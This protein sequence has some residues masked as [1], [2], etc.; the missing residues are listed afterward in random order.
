[1]LFYFT[2]F[3]LLAVPQFIL[4]QNIVI[5]NSNSPNE[6][7][8]AMDY[9]NPSKM[10]AG[11]NLNNYYISQDTGRTWTI[12]SL[13]SSTLGV[14]GDP[15]M[16]I[17]TAGVYYFLHLSNPP[18]GN[19]IDRIV[20][21]RSTDEGLTWNDGTYMGLNGTKAQDKE[22]VDIDRNKNILYV[23]WTQFDNY[24]S[25]NPLDSSSILFSKSTDQGL[26]WSPALRINE[27]SGDC[28]DS[29]N[30][31]EGAVPAVGPNGEIYVAWAGPEGIVF[32]RSTDEGS[33]WL[34]QDIPV[35]PMPTGWDYSIPGL[36]R[37]NGLPVTKCDLSG[38]PNH[39]DIYVFWSDQRNGPNDTDL[40]LK[41]SSDGGNTWSNLIR[42][43]NDPPGSHQFMG[44]LTVDQVSGYL[45]V[46]YYDRSNYTDTNT[47]VFA[48]VSTDG[49]QTWTHKKISD[50][51]FIP[52]GSVFFGDYT[53]IIA[54][55]G[56]VRPIWTRMQNGQRSIL[57]ELLSYD[58]LVSRIDFPSIKPQEFTFYPNPIK[59]E[60]MVSYKI[61]GPSIVDISIVDL[62]GNQKG[63]I[64]R[65]A[66]RDYGKYTESYT[67]QDPELVKG[68]YILEI[69]INGNK[70]TRKLVVE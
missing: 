2:T 46:I 54:Y 25:T 38:G 32:D 45:Y 35:D 31:T 62:M 5:S 55:D 22:W 26:S 69:T 14:W 51:P 59:D 30:T 7:S 13:S 24:G 6:P 16:A 33:T 21:Q 3:L 66:F 8:I 15:V 18:S 52:T 28:I 11:A 37:C 20:C 64:L 63:T 19:W 56:I 42:V 57:T 67:S 43:N 50:Q 49:G 65:N 23:T 60:L 9:R 12:N 70:E 34:S 27:V 61:H 17:D 39:G 53:N 68:V 29:D 47:D 36:Y 4:A 1:M 44:W 58:K 10:I 48:G 41:R 40:F